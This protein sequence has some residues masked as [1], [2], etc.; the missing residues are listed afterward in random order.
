M[1]NFVLSNK[2]RPIWHGG[3]EGVCSICKFKN[4]AYPFYVV[5]EGLF[6][7][8]PYDAAGNTVEKVV[9]LC[10]DHAA[11]LKG[12]LDDI[13]PDPRLAGLQ[14]RVLSAEAARARAEKRAEKAEAALY[15]LQDWVS[16]KPAVL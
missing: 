2:P 6:E 4:D 13:I 14:G 9:Q 1:A 3:P 11:E 15:A 12:V 16:E 5:F 7:E 10:C 8:S